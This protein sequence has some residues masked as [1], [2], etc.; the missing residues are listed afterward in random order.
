M[1]MKTRKLGRTALDVGVI[2]LGVEHLVPCRENMNAVLDLAVPAG[3]NY[4]DLIYN[5]PAEAHAR[6]WE[7]IGPA[8]RRHRES[9]VLA[10]HWGFVEH[11]AI[12]HC[13]TSF[14]HALNQVGNDYAEIAM[15]TK[16]D[17]QELWQGWAQESIRRLRQYQR[18]GRVGF[19]GISSHDAA[20]ALA[21][22]EPGLIDVLMFPINLY[23]HRGDP[24]RAALLDGCAEHQVGVIA[25]KPYYGGRLLSTEG[26]PTGIT[27]AQCL[28]YVLSQAVAAAVPGAKDAD[29]MRQAL[30]YLKASGAETQHVSMTD[31]LAQRLRGQ[32]VLCQHCLPCPQG[33]R[34]P[35][36]ISYLDYVEYFGHGLLLE[37]ARRQWYA[38]LSA[39]ASD[40]IE[41][42]VCVERCPFKVDIIGKMRR[43]VEVFESGPGARAT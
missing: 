11:E 2:G 31:D 28:H 13:Q 3:V 20:V 29:E 9:L 40:C 43:A 19:I 5:D 36:L 7:A 14:D 10:V 34:V 33:I 12:E 26:R 21:A 4:V 17:T 25:M 37:H 35:D 8:L 32:C 41:C 16:V 38:S 30:G 24:A 22:V 23:Q 42:G 39:G 15:L 18:A 6:H 1:R 27:P